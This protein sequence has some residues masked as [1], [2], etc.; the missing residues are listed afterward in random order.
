MK[1]IQYNPTT[2]KLKHEGELLIPRIT[3]DNISIIN[4][5]GKTINTTTLIFNILKLDKHG[6]VVVRLDGNVH[7]NAIHNLELMTRNECN[8]FY[9]DKRQK[10][11]SNGE[12]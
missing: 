12:K 7:N 9:F 3:R 4:F 2:G 11:N 5:R 8:Q 10:R 1:D 6:M